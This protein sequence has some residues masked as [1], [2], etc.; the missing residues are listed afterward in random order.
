MQ[1]A[2]KNKLSE[3]L[4]MAGFLDASI[5]SDNI[6]YAQKN[7]IDKTINNLEIYIKSRKISYVYIITDGKE[8]K[9]IVRQETNG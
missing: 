7:N 1:K 3:L 2:I 8:C 9:Y 4:K 5:D 6:Y